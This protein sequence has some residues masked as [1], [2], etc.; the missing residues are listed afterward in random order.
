MSLPNECKDEWQD[1]ETSTVRTSL[2]TD[3]LH[4]LRDVRAP[5]AAVDL[6]TRLQGLVDTY[7][8]RPTKRIPALVENVSLPNDCKDEWRNKET[9]SVE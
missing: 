1:Q 8:V 9:Y 4:A 6:A 2:V 3:V 7:K 5:L